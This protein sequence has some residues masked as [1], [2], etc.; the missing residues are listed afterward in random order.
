MTRGW[1]NEERQGV[2]F[3][4]SS[5]KILIFIIRFLSKILFYMSSNA[6][7]LN[8]VWELETLVKDMELPLKSL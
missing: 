4:H 2:F 8:E 1:I 3:T 6:I 5:Y 7:L